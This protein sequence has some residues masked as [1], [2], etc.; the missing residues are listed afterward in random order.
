[1]HLGD[2][3]TPGT[4]RGDVRHRKQCRGKLYSVLNAMV[5]KGN[6]EKHDFTHVK[7]SSGHRP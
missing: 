6:Q 2:S 1:M 3:L 4:V 7:N 5:H